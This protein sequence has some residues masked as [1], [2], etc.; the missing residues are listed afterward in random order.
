MRP[1]G[2]RTRWR[3]GPVSPTWAPDPVIQLEA[4]PGDDGDCLWLEW[5][6]RDGVTRRLLVDGGRGS[7]R[8]IPL[9]LAER[10]D[11]QPAD[12]R[13]FDLL[14]CTHIDAD[15]IGGLVALVSEPPPGFR[16]AD[17][18]FNGRR[19]LDLLGPAQGDELSG[20]LAR[21]SLPWNTAFGGRAVVVSH[22]GDLPV[23]Q[24]PGLRITL[25][26]PTY[27][28]LAAL[29]RF[30]PRVLADAETGL[31]QARPPADVLRREDTDREV[32]LHRLTTRPYT[33]DK[34]AANGSSIAF[35]AED[36]DGN[37]VL[38][39]A[40]AAAEV[41]T[42]SLRRVAG[43]PGR[44]RIDVCKVPHHGSRHNTSPEFLALVD[45]R[46]WLISTSGRRHRH[47]HR[48]AMARIL[49]RPDEAT[50]WF[51][52]RGPTTE[53]YAGTALGARYGF[54]VELPEDMG[55]GIALR[56]DRGQVERAG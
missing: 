28:Q 46:H 31:A 15:H 5:R 42:S 56:V 27:A 53:E 34:S 29:A 30:W 22:R 14:V 9:G 49:C 18:W 35:L 3:P 48:E 26:S 55:P 7:P 20:V 13:D 11:R 24:L 54:S 12:Q 8:Q 17:I 32:E 43:A 50:A 23:A 16:V 40:D 51:N 25:L 2:G 21:R 44:Y 6:D 19:H 37:R 10:L 36:D 4:L 39:A 1:A 41:L 52:Y 33:P 45:C 47:P 38:L